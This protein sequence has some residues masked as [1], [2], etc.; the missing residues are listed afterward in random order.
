LCLGDLKVSV[1]AKEN[2][3]EAEDERPSK[4]IEEVND[5]EQEDTW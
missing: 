4:S 2:D 3:E 1:H 5:A